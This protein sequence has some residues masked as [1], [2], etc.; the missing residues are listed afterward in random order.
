[1][2]KVKTKRE[3][4]LFEALIPIIVL[5]GVL[6]PAILIFGQDPHIPIVIAAE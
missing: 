1:M 3:A 4:S 5:I 2:S 6:I